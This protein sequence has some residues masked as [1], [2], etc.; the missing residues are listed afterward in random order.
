MTDKD[1][2]VALHSIG[3]TA[4]VEHFALF[5]EYAAGRLSAT[6]CE[7]E[8]A[9]SDRGGAWRLPY[10]KAIFENGRECD[11]LREVVSSRVPDSVRTDAQTLLTALCR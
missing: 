7:N 8:L 3:K 4:F 5:R 11:A 1:V 2:A 6:D 9:T 10:A